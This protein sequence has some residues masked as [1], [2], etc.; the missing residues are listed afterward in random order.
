MHAVAVLYAV[1][2]VSTL[3]SLTSSASGRC[4]YGPHSCT[5]GVRRPRGALT[6][7]RPTDSAKPAASTESGG[8]RSVHMHAGARALGLSAVFCSSL[9]VDVSADV[10]TDRCISSS[11][12]RKM[13]SATLSIPHYRYIRLSTSRYRV[14]HITSYHSPQFNARTRCI[15][16]DY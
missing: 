7:D 13:I 14:I 2:S 9:S 10:L 16:V 6:T 3:L 12:S 1:Q 8:R 11:P 4:H 5:A 15:F